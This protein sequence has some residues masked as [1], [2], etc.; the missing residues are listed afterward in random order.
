MALK[1][2]VEVPQGAIRLNTDSQKLEFFA[3]D[4]WW[5]M[6]TENAPDSTLGGRGV[7]FGGQGNPPAYTKD[8]TIDYITISTTGDAIDFGNLTQAVSHA[9]ACGSTTRGYQF[10]GQ[11]PTYL[12]NI[13][14]ITFSSTGNSVDSGDLTQARRLLGGCNSNTRAI[15]MAGGPATDTIDYWTMAVGGNA[16]DFGNLVATN[17]FNESTSNPIYGVD[18]KWND[19]N[20]RLDYITIA[21]TGNAVFFGNL[22]P[23]HD[24]GAQT[25]SNAIRGF[26]AGGYSSPDPA[27]GNAKW[28]DYFTYTTKGNTT[29]FGEL[30]RGLAESSGGSASSATRIAFMGNGPGSNTVGEQVI[31]YITIQTEG[32]AVDFG[33]LSHERWVAPTTSNSNG[34]TQ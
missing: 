3:Q 8:D 14:Y 4:Q 32:N 18:H 7:C 15:R 27:I 19:S 9:A 21:T 2:P 23:R 30:T 1:P 25:G 34:G 17:M 28:I 31:D 22:K 11:T 16:V 6:A 29:A 24:T 12:N 33:D 5:Q 13:E 20:G 10:G 26:W